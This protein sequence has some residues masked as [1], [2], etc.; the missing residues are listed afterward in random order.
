MTI[1]LSPPPAQQR[2]EI[3]FE[4]YPMPAPPSLFHPTPL[5]SSSPSSSPL[6]VRRQSNDSPLQGSPT[7][8]PKQMQNTTAG[9]GS[10]QYSPNEV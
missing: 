9:S 1:F 5:P 3:K 4:E 6:S 8:T 7:L 10:Y 2:K